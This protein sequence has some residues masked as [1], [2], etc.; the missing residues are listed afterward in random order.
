VTTTWSVWVKAI[1]RTF[2]T[3]YTDYG[4][5]GRSFQLTGDGV[6][7]S[8]IGGPPTNSWIQNWGNGWY[9]IGINFTANTTPSQGCYVFIAEA[10]NDQLFNGNSLPAYYLWGAQVVTAALT[11]DAA[12]PD[13]TYV[14]TTTATAAKVADVLYYKGDDGNLGG[15]GS[16]KRGRISCNILL[17][18]MDSTAE[19]TVW[20]L[21]DGGG[22]E[23]VYVYVD[24]TGDDANLRSQTALSDVTAGSVADV[25]SGVVVAI[26]A[27]WRDDSYVRL[28]TDGVLSSGSTP[29]DI[30]DDLERLNIGSGVG[31]TFH[32]NGM[33]NSVKVFKK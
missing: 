31:G 30:A 10:D 17:P 22:T 13:T 1:N 21:S 26:D 4:A 2:V 19:K 3:L 11:T 18:N 8:A 12:S 16:N 5:Q 28:K 29:T 14:P 33:I 6:I 23:R 9:R 7:G 20:A 32:L 25:A 27:S 15:I 24:V